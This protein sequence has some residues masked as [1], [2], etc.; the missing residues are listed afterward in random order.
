MSKESKPFRFDL[1]PKT[2]IPGRYKDK[3]V[4]RLSDLRGFFS[5]ND[6]VEG[7]LAREKNPIIYEVYEI[8]QIPSEGLFSLACTVLHPGKVGR[9]YYF[10][11]GHFHAKEPTSEVYVGLKGEGVILLQTRDGRVV[12]LPLKAG[13]VVYIPPRWAHRS[14]NTGKGKFVFLAIY[15]SDAGHDYESIK[16]NGFARIVVERGRKPTLIKNPA[17]KGK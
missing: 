15:P 3:Q 10:T 4:R 17:R 14:I 5:D 13:G 7:L 8:P 1:D 11:K 2:G 12:P 6:L 9:E 16:R